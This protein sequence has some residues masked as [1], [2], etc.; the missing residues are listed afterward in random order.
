MAAWTPKAG[1]PVMLDLG[2]ELAKKITGNAA[3][4]WLGD[5][6]PFL[7]ADLIATADMCSA[8]PPA[9]GSL[10]L[11]DLIGALAP[12]GMFAVPEKIRQVAISQIFNDYC[13]APA[14][15]GPAQPCGSF[16]SAVTNIPNGTAANLWSA[17]TG[18]PL[19]AGAS[20][21]S[22]RVTH[23]DPGYGDSWG[24][25]ILVQ[26]ADNSQLLSLYTAPTQPV[27]SA[28]FDFGPLSLPAWADHVN[29]QVN[30]LGATYSG[31]FQAR[32]DVMCVGVPPTYTPPSQPRPPGF[33]S[34]PTGVYNTT[35]DLGKMLDQLE[36]KLDG[37]QQ[38]LRYLAQQA[39]PPVLVGATD[40]PVNTTPGQKVPTGTAIGAVITVAGIP[41]AVSEDFADVTTFLNL[42]RV[43]LWTE[44]GPMA[45]IKIEHNP[46]V[47][48]PF[49]SGVKN[50]SVGVMRPAT[51]SVSLL[52]APK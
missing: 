46:M 18:L 9:Q 48:A 35:Q 27:S 41:P 44:F 32:V 6:V 31:H 29:A 43:T 11:G 16:T 13:Q 5:Y 19:P 15:T 10:G 51:A 33:I 39:P 45:P 42:G 50:V 47:V 17:V 25:I 26:N 52:Y 1:A 23:T 37:V 7:G 20:T 40:P 24:G 4:A 22:G 21:I 28:G 8:G 2:Q 12:F 34:P 49:P 36:L 3:L 38:Q 30:V 14:P